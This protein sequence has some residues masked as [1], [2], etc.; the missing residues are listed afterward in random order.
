[1]R[2]P[3]PRT[4]RR[5]PQR[6]RGA[7]HASDDRGAEV[8]EQVDGPLDDPGHSDH[9]HA[10][11]HQEEADDH[12]HRAEE[13]TDHEGDHPVSPSA[14]SGRDAPRPRAAPT[15]STRPRTRPTGTTSRPTST[16]RTPTTRTPLTRRP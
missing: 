16:T 15:P 12:D 9:E 11:D 14:R 4:G 13:H 7:G 1:G 5:H 8:H 6:L 3:E 2:L 10:D